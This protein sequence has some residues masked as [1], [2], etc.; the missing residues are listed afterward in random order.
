MAKR[1]G[2]TDAPVP[3]ESMEVLKQAPEGKVLLVRNVRDGGAISLRSGQRGMEADPDIVIE[4]QCEVVVPAAWA[5]TSADLKKYI[6]LGWLTVAWVDENYEPR[7]LPSP[8]D[9][10]GEIIT[11]LTRP[12]RLFAFNE[13]A[14]QS[15]QAKAIAAV[16]TQVKQP[17]PRD[18]MVDT[19]YMRDHFYY[20][21][22]L[23]DWL[24]Q[25]IHNRAKVRSA[26]KAAKAAIRDM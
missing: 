5:Q 13:I 25:Q 14:L 6:R 12:E 26:I 8:D 16:Q 19:R 18:G 23:A 11:H 10:P 3:A 22:E 20:V 15:D 24:E 9:A 2:K 7:K 1:T 4:R 17:E 21:L